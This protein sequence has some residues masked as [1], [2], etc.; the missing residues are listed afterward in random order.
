MIGV[1]RERIRVWLPGSL[2][3]AS[4]DRSW[5]SHKETSRSL[6]AHWLAANRPLSVAASQA[7]W[8]ILIEQPG[9]RRRYS[10]KLNI[11]TNSK[12]EE[13]WL[14][15]HNSLSYCSPHLQLLGI[16]DALANSLGS[17]G[18]A[19][20]CPGLWGSSKKRPKR[21]TVMEASNKQKI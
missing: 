17:Y 4:Q 10:E 15:M 21:A 6:S 5:Q 11:E 14:V 3:S 8:S 9:A 18:P 16:R 13:K 7:I 19:S 20:P 12:Y 1:S 2:L